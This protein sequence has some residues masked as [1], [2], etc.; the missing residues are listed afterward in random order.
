MIDTHV[1]VQQVL[2]AQLWIC[3]SDFVLHIVHGCSEDARVV[4][5]VGAVAMFVN[6]VPKKSLVPCQNMCENY[7]MCMYVY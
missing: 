5:R 6:L 7:C 4:P 3:V 2:F 1:I